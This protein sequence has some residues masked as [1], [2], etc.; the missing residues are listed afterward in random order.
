MRPV[1]TCVSNVHGELKAARGGSVLFCVRMDSGSRHFVE[2]EGKELYLTGKKGV[3][4]KFL[5]NGL[6]KQAMKSDME[7]YHS[8]AAV[9]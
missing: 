9:L 7:K 1:Q 3:M 6:L 5:V 8:E 2:C 4:M